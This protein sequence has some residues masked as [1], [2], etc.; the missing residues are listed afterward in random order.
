MLDCND[1]WKAEKICARIKAKLPDLAQ[2][3]ALGVIAV[4]DDDI[5]NADKSLTKIQGALPS[6]PPIP[7]M[8]LPEKAARV[9]AEPGVDS[10]VTV[11]AYP[12]VTSATAGG[13]PGWTMGP[14]CAAKARTQRRW[15]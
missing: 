3:G 2:H 13:G 1:V 10:G 11:T 4:V 12:D 5:F 8:L 6:R 7:I 14:G 15:A 9:L